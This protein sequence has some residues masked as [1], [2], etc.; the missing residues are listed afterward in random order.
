MKK[1]S[2]KATQYFYVNNEVPSR[3]PG[4]IVVSEAEA[5]GYR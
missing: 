3:L 2:K 4:A 1:L 5:K